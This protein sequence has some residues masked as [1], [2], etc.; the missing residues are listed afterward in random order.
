[1]PFKPDTRVLKKFA[2]YMV[3]ATIYAVATFGGTFGLMVLSYYLTESFLPFWLF[4]VFLLLCSFVYSH[5]E[6]VVSWERRQ[7][8]EKD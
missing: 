1:M 3:T 6:A 2:S 7:E 4:A 5:A 8:A